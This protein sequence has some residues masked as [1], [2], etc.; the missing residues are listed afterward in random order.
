[1]AKSSKKKKNFHFK[2][3]YV[4]F[5]E[6]QKGLILNALASHSAWLAQQPR[7]LVEEEAKE[8][9]V[10]FETITR[11]FDETGRATGAAEYAVENEEQRVKDELGL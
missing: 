6:R 3:K 8:T 4:N 1:V 10:L 5:D 2:D 9:M 7:H 11:G